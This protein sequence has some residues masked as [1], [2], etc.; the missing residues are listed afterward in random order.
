M[1]RP[2]LPPNGRQPNRPPQSKVKAGGR[3]PRNVPKN[4]TPRNILIGLAVSGVIAGVVWH[5]NTPAPRKRAPVVAAPA[6]KVEVL[7]VPMEAP[8]ETAPPVVEE[9][10]PEVKME[11]VK[12]TPKETVVAAVVNFPDR[13]DLNKVTGANRDKIEQRKTFLEKAFSTRDWPGY[14]K[15]LHDSLDFEILRTLR[16][17]AINTALDVVANPLVLT[18][19]LQHAFLAN[20]G[21]EATAVIHSSE[22]SEKAC[23]FLFEN[24]A[25][26]S[27]F[28]GS[29][30][31]QDE[32]DKVL[33]NLA[34]ILAS[35]PDASGKYAELAMACALV[36]D[37]SLK[38]EATDQESAASVS[39]L[40][41]FQWFRQRN[42]E[43]KLA[44]KMEEQ[45]VEDLIWVVCSSSTHQEMDWALKNVR[46]NQKS[47]GKAYA[48]IRYRMDKA[49]G[50]VKLYKEYTLA[51]VERQGGV[52]SDQAYFSANTAR[53]FGIPA[54]IIVGDGDRGLH[55]WMTW[56]SSE[57]S[58]GFAG[59]YAGYPMGSVHEPSSGGTIG[60]D[61][62]IVK[63]DPK[64]SQG[65][66]VEIA[67]QLLWLA[68]LYA[69][70][71]DLA[72]TALDA[73]AQAAPKLPDAISA[74]LEN[75]MAHRSGESVAAWKTLL[76]GIKKDFAY[77][78]QMMELA[79]TAQD[80]YVFARQSAADN[81]EDMKRDAKVATKASS[82]GAATNAEAIAATI[83]RTAAAS[84]EKGD[85][86]GVHSIYKKALKEHASNNLFFMTLAPNY[87][88]LCKEEAREAKVCVSNIEN[89]AEREVGE[90]PGDFFEAGKMEEA[91]SIVAKMWEDIGEPKKAEKVQKTVT[92]LQ[93][94][95]QSERSAS[96]T[97]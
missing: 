83:Q 12:E 51:E 97:N 30:T 21:E 36:F 60:E 11:E 66:R 20:L 73:A 57:K 59:R 10:K 96:K 64:A 47:W 53:A 58:W 6:P 43:G 81:E 85:Y 24:P 49:A 95:V 14:S 69:E 44:V 33:E 78:T 23:R 90:T 37:K 4:N 93:A 86:T 15:M 40:E 22:Q 35:T 55:A 16:A 84:Q 94:F 67:R 75:W 38:T 28:M 54:A 76:Q 71:P 68:K 5:L 18:H 56:K 82:D 45:R 48:D 72:G 52:C 8:K 3:P 80:K 87:F 77:H 50:G 26:L 2:S 41:R 63:G 92:K 32:L 79:R 62:F 65:N 31:E 88:D 34:Q 91:W 1:K 74:Q 13:L 27:S 42:E 70:K 39:G 17:G 61:V 46:Q 89:V 29:H 7:D 19:V 25:R 9:V